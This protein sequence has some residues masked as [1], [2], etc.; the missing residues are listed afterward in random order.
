MRRPAPSRSPPTTVWRPSRSDKTA[1]PE[2]RREPATQRLSRHTLVVG[3]IA[4]AGDQDFYQVSL[5]TRDGLPRETKVAVFL[6]GAFARFRPDRQQVRYRRSSRRP[7]ARLQSGRRRSKTTASGSRPPASRSHRRRCRTC[8]SARPRSA[9]RRS[10]RRLSGARRRRGVTRTR[11]R[12]SLRPARAGS[13]RSTSPV[14]RQ[15]LEQRA[16]HVYALRDAAAAAAASCPARF[17]STVA[18]PSSGAPGA[19]LASLP[20]STKSLFVVTTSKRL[21]AIF[22]RR[23][24]T[25]IGGRRQLHLG[26]SL[27]VDGR[28]TERST[29]QQAVARADTLPGMRTRAIRI[30]PTTWCAAIN[31]VVAS[32]RNSATGR[33]PS[34]T[35]SSCSGTDEAL[36]M[37]RTP[38]PVTLSP[39]EYEASDLAF[40]TNGITTGNALRPRCSTISSPSDAALSRRAFL[41]SATTC[42]SLSSP[43]RGSSRARRTCS[44]KY[45]PAP[46]AEWAIRRYTAERSIRSR[47]SRP[48]TTFSPTVP[49]P[50]ATTCVAFR[51]P[52]IADSFGCQPRQSSD[53]RPSLGGCRCGQRPSC[54]QAPPTS[55]R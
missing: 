1:S 31:D 30:W 18:Q 17:P 32:Y 21:A 16:L 14:T 39:E 20:S 43:S 34:L 38:D 8:R 5:K 3:H 11:R 24:F 9:P 46:R 55:C 35:T 25:N 12:R 29:E 52:A 47:S 27:E 53:A 37:A 10:A 4:V 54:V 6:K 45:K 26:G 22:G 50:S 42:C 44:G 19:L 13:R 48:A 33:L 40:T 51:R 2:Q 7:S 23:P 41:G 49:R 15:R 28:R 36:P